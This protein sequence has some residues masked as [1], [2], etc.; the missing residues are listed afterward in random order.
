MQVPSAFSIT[1]F[2]P[3]TRADFCHVFIPNLFFFTTH[4]TFQYLFYL[5]RMTPFCN[6]IVPECTL[7]DDREIKIVVNKNRPVM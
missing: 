2:I 6:L 3:H 5:S 7:L 1:T 4:V